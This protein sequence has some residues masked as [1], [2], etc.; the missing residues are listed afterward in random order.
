MD[1][2]RS[3]EKAKLKAE[4]TL[5]TQEKAREDRVK[6]REERIAARE[7]ALA[8][9]AEEEQRIKDKADRARI[10]RQRRREGETVDTSEESEGEG[11]IKPKRSRVSTPVTG[12]KRQKKAGGKRKAEEGWELACEICRKTGWNLVS[13]FGRIDILLRSLC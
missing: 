5:V 13:L 4:A 1:K 8:Q 10:R 11:S 6:E 2:S 7:V 12:Q 3:E 9:K